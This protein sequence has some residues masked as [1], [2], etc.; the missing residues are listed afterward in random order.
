MNLFLRS[1]KEDIQHPNQE[2]KNVKISTK[3]PFQMRKIKGITLD[4]CHENS[5]Q[6]TCRYNGLG[7]RPT[8]LCGRHGLVPKDDWIPAGSQYWDIRAG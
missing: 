3:T 6:T 8:L 4:S 5:H 2:N 7:T 1:G